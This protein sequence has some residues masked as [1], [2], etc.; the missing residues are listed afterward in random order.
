MEIPNPN[1]KED[2]Q[3]LEAQFES[4][5]EHLSNEYNQLLTHQLNSQRIYFEQ[6]LKELERESKTQVET[7]MRNSKKEKEKL[8]KTI[9]KLQRDL[10]QEKKESEILRQLNDRLIENQNVYKK[11]LEEKNKEI[12]DL[13]EQVKDLMFYIETQQKIEKSGM[14]EELQNGQIVIQQGKT[15]EKKKRLKGKKR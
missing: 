11:Q 3:V 2:A 4:K 7:Y 5:L 13:K 1:S 12:E 15:T 6:R 9:E 14:K 8:N 10:Q